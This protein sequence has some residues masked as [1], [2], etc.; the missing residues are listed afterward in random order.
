MMKP[1]APQRVLALDL[2]PL[3][4]GYAIFDRP[5]ELLDWGIRNFRHG[6]NAVKVPLGVK[7][8][9]LLDL[10]AP[11]VIAIKE[12][13]TTKL[14]RM[15][16]KIVTL[17]QPREIPARLISG[18]FVRTAFPGNNQTK[19]HIATVIAA[20]YPELSPRLGT[21]RT[22]WQAE[23]YSMSIFDAAAL[24]VAFFIHDTTPGNAGDRAFSSLPR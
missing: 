24:G 7:L 4:F 18:D 10:Y 11:D 12:P 19:Y 14:K 5:D 1:S 16:R 21:R 8:A 22:L 17:A 13:R 3:S 20:R 9:L 15:V 2:H 6:V 23:K